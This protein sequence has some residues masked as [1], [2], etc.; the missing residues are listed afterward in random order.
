MIWNHWKRFESS[1][2]FQWLDGHEWHQIGES[3]DVKYASPLPDRTP[4]EV[5]HW[6]HAAADF[7]AKDVHGSGAWRDPHHASEQNRQAG[8]R[9]I[10]LTD[11]DEKPTPISLTMIGTDDG[12]NWWKLVGTHKPNGRQVAFDFGPKVRGCRRPVGRRPS[13]DVTD[14][15][16]SHRRPLLTP[17]A[18]AGWAR[19]PH[20]R[21]DPL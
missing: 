12:A 9:Y 8:M 19:H 20:G 7:K 15:T 10:A 16:D 21:L 4:N 17:S 13:A 5:P 11:A 6:P 1:V 3:S 14:V 18:D 2:V